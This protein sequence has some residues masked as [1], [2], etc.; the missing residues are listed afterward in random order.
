[1]SNRLW[2]PGEVAD[3][4][5]IN[6]T[7]VQ[8]WADAGLLGPVTRTAGGHRRYTSAGVITRWNALQNPKE[9]S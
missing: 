2:T 4:F 1:M 3:L 5:K 6:P 9:K 7:T 8:R